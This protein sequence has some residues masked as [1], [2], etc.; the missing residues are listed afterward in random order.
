[1]TAFSSGFSTQISGDETDMYVYNVLYMYAHGTLLHNNYM[2][3][4]MCTCTCTCVS[5]LV[6]PVKRIG[7][8]RLL[9]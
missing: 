8:H 2:C 3:I 6:I 1:M 9:C 7:M 5:V 4:Y